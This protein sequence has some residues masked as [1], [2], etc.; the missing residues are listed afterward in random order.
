MTETVLIT[1]AAGRIG[2]M[3]RPRLA[4]PGRVLRLLDQAEITTGDPAAAEEVITGSLT[5]A[6]MMRAA[7]D[8]VDAVVHLGGYPVEQSFADILQVNV[9][10]TQVVLEAAREQGVPRVVLAS[11]NHA[12]GFAERGDAA[13]PDDLAPRPD[14]WYG[15]GK[16]AMES[17]GRLYADRF[18]MDVVCLRIGSCAEEPFD[19]RS[20][21]TWLSPGD[22]GRLCEAA[23]DPAVR[24]FHLVWG[25]SANTRSW[26]SA[27]GG[28]SIGFHPVDDAEPWAPRLLARPDARPD[29]AIEL[30]RVGGA[31]PTA[32]LGE[33]MS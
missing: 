12:V 17:M 23:L 27:D 3:L 30:R 21:S 14:T 19:V 5:D 2:S 22:A 7:C 16:T 31:F 15:W 33:P 8:G 18:G 20:L 4:R 24:G 28:A 9:V 32:P 1:G 10:G 29:E 25:V 26:W 11:S 6:S 13:A